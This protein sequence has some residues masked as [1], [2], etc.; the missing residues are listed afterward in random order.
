[1]NNKLE[2]LKILSFSNPIIPIYIKK[3][4]SDQELIEIKRLQNIENEYWMSI[5]STVL[6]PLELINTSN[7]VN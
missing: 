2:N 3:P 7:Q 5:G 1:M 6:K 4:V